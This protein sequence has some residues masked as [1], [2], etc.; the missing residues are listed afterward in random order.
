MKIL[1]EEGGGRDI[2]FWAMSK[3][4]RLG[5]M[6]MMLNVDILFIR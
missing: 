2:S 1:E 3:E 5:N 6:V 4:V